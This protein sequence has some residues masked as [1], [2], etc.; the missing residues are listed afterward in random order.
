MKKRL[1][2]IFSAILVV[3]VGLGFGYFV[4]LNNSQRIVNN[5]LKGSSE[6]KCY[7]KFLQLGIN[8]YSQ[9]NYQ[10][11][12]KN[13]KLAAKVYKDDKAAGFTVWRNIAN[14]YIG[15][16]QDVE[17]KKI[18]NEL[19]PIGHEDVTLVYLDYIAL[20]E[21]EKNYTKALEVADE[22]FKRFGATIYLYAQANIL[23]S[24]EKYSDEVKVYEALLK[25]DASN[26]ESIQFKIDR[27]KEVHNL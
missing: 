13:F 25:L 5:C 1:I 7:T 23:E 4:Y 16:G 26:T 2:I 21:K 3:L 22:A 17:A 9:E 6:A 12:L 18:F 19:L 14:S 24:M 15:L 20:Y 27:L 11:A 10:E 8:S